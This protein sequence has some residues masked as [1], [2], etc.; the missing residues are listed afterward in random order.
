MI[1]RLLLKNVMRELRGNK[2]GKADDGK[3]NLTYDKW[4]AKM[5]TT[6]IS[7]AITY[8]LFVQQSEDIVECYIQFVIIL[9]DLAI[10]SLT[11]NLL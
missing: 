2:S 11:T 9:Y 5:I 3:S 6:I 4:D 7:T 10:T 1:W 8:R